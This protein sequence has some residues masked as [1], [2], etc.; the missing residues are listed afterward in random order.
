MH[1]GH[2]AFAQEAMRTCKLGRVVFLPEPVPRSKHDVTPLPTRLAQ[3]KTAV[4]NKPTLQ[5]IAL[6]S[7]QFTVRDTLPTLERMFSGSNL[8]LLVGSDVLR[9]LQYWSDIADLLARTELIIGLRNN[10]TA[11][12]LA[13]TISSIQQQ[14]TID[15]RHTFIRTQYPNLSSSQYRAHT[16]L[17]Q[18]SNKP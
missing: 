5:V 7:E 6:P 16:S 11:E 10:D 13:D 2:I 4:V 3:L 17:G 9:T 8:A 18:S 15:I 1:P 12:T 14:H